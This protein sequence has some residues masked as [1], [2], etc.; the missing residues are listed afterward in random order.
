MKRQNGV[1]LVFA[2]L[3]L[4]CI[5]ILGVTAVSSSLMQGK[6]STSMQLNGLAFDA[7]EAAIAGVIFESEDEVV[8]TDDDIDDALTEARQGNVLDPS[9]DD[10]ACTDDTSWTNRQVTSAGLSA[11]EIQSLT[12]DFHSTPSV[13][14]WSRTAFIREQACKGSS[15][16]IGSSSLKCHVFVIRGCGQVENKSSITANT[17]TVAVFG[18]SS[19]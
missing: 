10:L 1:V 9:L 14:S 16:T 6:M 19:D 15:N 5:T 12:G 17:L 2:L 8:L 18:P 3:M 4:L 13:Q 11:G 7:A